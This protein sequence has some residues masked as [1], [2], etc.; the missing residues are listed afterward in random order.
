MIQEQVSKSTDCIETR[1]AELCVIARHL[2]VLMGTIQQGLLGPTP[3]EIE[4]EANK[5]AGP[6]SVL[7]S[8]LV[9]LRDLTAVQAQ[10]ELTHEGIF[11]NNVLKQH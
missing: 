4:R 8:L 2:R 9:A 7:E 1:A 5:T 3:A 6:T 11:G 10:M